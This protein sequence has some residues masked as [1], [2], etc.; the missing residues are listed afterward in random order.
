MLQGAKR[1]TAK[2]WCNQVL[3]NLRPLSQHGDLNHR[4]LNGID[5]YYHTTP[6]IPWMWNDG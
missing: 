1:E 2:D 4:V 5:I 3:S 6:Y